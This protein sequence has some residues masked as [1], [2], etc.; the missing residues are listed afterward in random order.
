MDS[1]WSTFDSRIAD[2]FWRGNQKGIGF[3]LDLPGTVE[4]REMNNNKNCKYRN[5]RKVI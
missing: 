3:G 1:E 5:V 2:I 4:D